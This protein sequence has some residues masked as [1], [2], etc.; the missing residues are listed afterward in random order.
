MVYV[1]TASWEYWTKWPL[2][3]HMVKD[4]SNTEYLGERL[5]AKNSYQYGQS[6]SIRL[7]VAQRC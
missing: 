6:V 4:L 7:T 2:F 3:Q 5:S 1:M